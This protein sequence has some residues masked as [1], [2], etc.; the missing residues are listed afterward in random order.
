[1]SP[2]SL[3]DS[4]GLWHVF[5][6]F[7]LGIFFLGQSDKVLSA[8]QQHQAVLR[9]TSRNT[10]VVKDCLVDRCSWRKRHNNKTVEI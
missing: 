6:A 8:V 4:F 2:L 1:M 9:E 10:K 3:K 5:S 7:F